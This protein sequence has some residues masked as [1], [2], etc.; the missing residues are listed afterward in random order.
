MKQITKEW[1]ISAKDDFKVIDK[2][3][4]EEYLAHRVAFHSQQAIEKTFKALVNEKEVKLIKTHDLL[5]L[6]EQIAEFINLTLD[7]ETLELLD[8]LYIDARYPGDL[9]LLPNGKPTIDDAKRFYEF[10]KN[11]FDNIKK[12]L[13]TVK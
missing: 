9:G 1:L 10:A 12:F 13:E 7:I 2:I 11:I 6:Y 5:T 8:K 4:E 3:I